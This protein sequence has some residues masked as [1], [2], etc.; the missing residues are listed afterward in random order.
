MP[1]RTGRLACAVLGTAVLATLAG[2]GSGGTDVTVGLITKQ[3]ENPYWVTMRDVAQTTADR[4]GV[5]LVTA[6]GTS[7]VDVDSQVEALEQ[8]TAD[9]VDGILI[10]PADSTALVPAIE[11]ARDEGVVVIAVDTPTDPTDAVDAVFSTDNVAAGRLVGGYARA[12]VDA[13]GAEP[14]VALL[15]LAPGI[16]SGEE[17][18]EGFLEGFG[19][20]ADDPAVVGRVDTQGDEDLARDAMTDLLAETPGINVVYTVNEPAASGA[21]TALQDAGVDPDDVV[22]VS[23]DGGCEAIRGLVRGGQVDA[24][25]Q[26]Y[27]ENMAREGVLA[28]AEAARGGETPTG[29]L[30]TGVRLISGNPL[31]GVDSESVEF[32]TR[33]CWG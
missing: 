18:L 15:D 9:G 27:P 26:Q 20:A 1:A 24:T 12:G 11:A 10:A 22:V 6:T 31:E 32:G 4:D 14:V 5:E 30:D 21:V 3:E 33:N 25:S 17:R 23:V 7:D 28:L 13:L 2:C 16:V 8:M 29:Y 19:I